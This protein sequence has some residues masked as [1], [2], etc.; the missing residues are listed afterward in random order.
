[1]R[2]KLALWQD[3][4]FFRVSMLHSPTIP[5]RWTD[6]ISRF[7]GKLRFNGAF[8]YGLKFGIAGVL[9]VFIS[10]L[11]KSQEPTWALFTVFVLMSAQYI[12]AIAEKSFLRMVGTVVG[13][14]LGYL[15]TALFEQ[16]PFIY[17]SLLALLVGFSAAMFGQNRYP[18]AFLLVALTACV[19]S[20]KGMQDPQNSYVFMIQRIQEVWIGIIA[21]ML[22]QSLIWPRYA[23]TEFLQKLRG[24]FSSL[25]D[26]LDTEGAISA[27]RTTKAHANLEI[28]L[29]SI[30]QLLKFGA[31]E[32]RYFQAR[33]DSY[34]DLLRC[35]R[36]IASSLAARHIDIPQNIYYSR[37]KDFFDA[38]NEC[39]LDALNELAQENSS[40]SSRASKR[41]EIDLALKKILALIVELRSDPHTRNIP[42]EESI[43]FGA[44]V[45]SIEEI[46]D[47]IF[48]SFD[49]LDALE[50][51]ATPQIHK[52][53]SILP[54]VP[55]TLWYYYGLR[56]A[57]AVV[58]AMILLNSFN[59]PGGSMIVVATFV[60]C[61]LMPIA[62]EGRGD[63]RSYHFFIQSTAILLLLALLLIA[64]T[65]LLSIYAV[66]NIL[67]FT[68][69]FAYGYLS[70]SI[71]GV[72]SI[73]NAAM[74]GLIG[75]LALNAQKP[76][77]FESIVD[78]FFGIALG[79]LIAAIFQRTFWPILPQKEMHSRF[80][81]WLKIL[82]TAIS[83]HKMTPQQKCRLILIPSEIQ[84][85]L[86]HLCPPIFPATETSHLQTIVAC[87]DR[88][89]SN[90]I[91]D[92]SL[93]ESVPTDDSEE[94]SQL[95]QNLRD[96]MLLTLQQLQSHFEKGVSS[97]DGISTLD[98]SIDPLEKWAA[99]IRLKLMSENQD[100]L[101]VC[102]IL[103]IA[104]RWK[105]AAS[106]L[107]EAIQIAKNL[108]P[109]TYLRDDSL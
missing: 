30:Q 19:V 46:R 4:G 26:L 74:L 70:F 39:L 14:V 42:V 87:L 9:A 103:G 77:S 56:T 107:A 36:Q 12:G 106:D 47:S 69:L 48:Q 80:L 105:N 88:F 44:H 35:A 79:M 23:S 5:I 10:L 109:T 86:P 51:K 98:S 94:A 63:H 13:G 81:E 95:T 58:C 66:L 73:M 20:S 33:L 54:E 41:K 53:Q 75:I 60:F 97:L 91:W 57:G 72:T 96:Q 40:S 83:T 8:I 85:R 100:P 25:R 16:E 37:T 78:F 2:R 38:L 89:S 6:E 59:P 93:P 52:A 55:S 17:L 84:I 31:W 28:E 7:L 82:T 76:V 22:V 64:A 67:L 50:K 62:P 71:V 45:L 32:S 11:N 101:L 108:H 21:V 99:A 65:P 43:I 15:L 49:A 29:V 104:A 68:W 1:M 24:T 18:Y 61:F 102:R 90:K 3:T 92:W 27:K 34:V